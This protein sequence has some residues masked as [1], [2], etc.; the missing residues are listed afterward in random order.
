MHGGGWSTKALPSSP[1]VTTVADHEPRA[2]VAYAL[3]AYLMWGFFPLYWSM[4]KAAP[5]TEVLGH[6]IVGTVVLL[7]AWLVGRRRL[8]TLWGLGRRRLLLLAGAS[9]L[10]SLNWLVYIWGVTHGHVV[11]TSL[12]YFIGPLVSVALGY[13]FL[14]E[15]L[16]RGQLL[17]IG[18]AGVAVAVLTVGFGRV[19]WIAGI[20]STSFSLYGL[21][22]KKAAVAPA[23]ALFLET[24]LVAPCALGWLLYLRATGGDTFLQL[25]GLHDGLLLLSGLA[26]AI[27]LLLFGA[28]ANRVSLSTLGILQYVAPSIQFVCGVVILGEPLPPTRLAGFALV[29]GALLVFSWDGLRA[30]R[31]LPPRSAESAG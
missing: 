4:L 14:G 29:W 19:P 30:R 5:A 11:E 15:R 6:R 7:G 26:T 27:P 8:H 20:L 25:G 24:S 3:G 16:R 31:P 23:P 13:G 18:L 10:I 12:G 21:V 9:A 1:A 2:G 28:G 22:K 17:A